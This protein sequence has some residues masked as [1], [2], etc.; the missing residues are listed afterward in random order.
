M[1]NSAS[2]LQR[3]ALLVSPAALSS[4]FSEVPTPQRTVCACVCVCTYLSREPTH[5]LL[6]LKMQEI[7]KSV[8]SRPGWLLKH[9]EAL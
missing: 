1:G 5:L 3:V 8:I 9:L 7:L 4:I 6:L 2:S